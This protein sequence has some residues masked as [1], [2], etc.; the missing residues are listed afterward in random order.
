MEYSVRKMGDKLKI[1]IEKVEEGFKIKFSGGFRDSNE[2]V[3]E[4]VKSLKIRVDKKIDE[5]FK[6]GGLEE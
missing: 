3:A 6:E 2:S 5:T 1:E 4:T